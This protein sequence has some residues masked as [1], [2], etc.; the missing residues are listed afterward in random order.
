MA[1]TFSVNEGETL[2]DPCKEEIKENWRHWRV[3][4]ENPR[5]LT[6]WH[7]LCCTDFAGWTS[8]GHL[9]EPRKKRQK[10]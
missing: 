5:V 9:K 8:Q 4:I 2:K 6:M 1:K 7:L 3:A 10:I